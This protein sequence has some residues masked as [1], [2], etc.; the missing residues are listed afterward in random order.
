M[1]S[2]AGVLPPDGRLVRRPPFQAP[3]HTRRL[4]ALV[5]GGTGLARPGRAL[6][7]PPRRAVPG[8]GAGVRRPGP[9]RAAPAAGG[10]AGWCC[11]RAA[12]R[13]RV[14]GP[15]P[16]GA[17]GQPV[18]VRRA[19][20]RR[21]LPCTPVARRRYLG[22]LS[23]PLLDRIDLQV[24]A[25]AGQ[26]RAQ[27]MTAT[28]PA[29]PSAVVAE[30]V[31]EARAAA[32]ARWAAAAGGSTPRCPARSCAAA[33]AAAAGRRR[34]R[35]DAAS[36]AAS[37]RP[38]AS[39]ACCG[40]P[41][42]SPT[43]T[44]ATGPDRDDV[45]EAVAAADGRG[46]WTADDPVRGSHGSR[47]RGWPS[48]ATGG[49]GRAGP[50]V[51]PV[52][53]LAPARSAATSPDSTLRTAV[54]GAG[55][56]ARR[57]RGGSPR[58]RSG[59]PSGSAPAS[60]CRR[61][62][63]GRRGS[64]TLATLELGRRRP[65]EPRHRPAALPAGR[66]GPCAAAGGVRAVGRGRRRP[67]RHRLRRCTSRPRS[68]YGLA[69]HGLD[70]GVRRRVRHRRG[71]APGG[72]R[73]PAA[74]RWRCSRAGST[75][76]TRRATPRCSSGIADAGL[77][78]SEWPPGAE[79]LRHRFLIRNRVIAAATRGTVVV[80]AAAR[81]GASQTMS[82]RA[83][84][85]TGSR[86][87]CPARSRRRCRSAATSCCAR[88]R[89]PPG[90]RPA[91]RAGGGG[92]DRRVPGRAAAPA[93]PSPRLAR[94]GVG[95]GAGGGATARRRGSGGTGGAGRAWACGPCCAGCRCWR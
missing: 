42:R 58:R 61:T 66:R 4:A 35:S 27:L 91:A 68:A 87:W 29:E 73:P 46:V 24:D 41:G 94:R 48:R 12:G 53:A 28:V 70:R 62:P 20:R 25:A 86:W 55:M 23:G 32:A 80:E 89:D 85:S 69:E 15:V 82:R 45:D 6:A 93:A 26:R 75:G 81:S 18:P 72:A 43:W 44:A 63:S 40:W 65:G 33:V 19:G 95:P 1:H 31:A 39:T 21:R 9:G 10:A 36:T 34:R 16:A 59:G 54:V 2:I 37:C 84:R 38:A 5:G 83:R 8:R 49:A 88:I 7:G 47:W 22:R 74:A 14:P 77:L 3:H 90:D 64:R 60:W 57:S 30:R 17:G 13:H 11:A 52:E 76:R 71:R 50:P 78:V 51:G 92:T 79:P 56:P 67:R